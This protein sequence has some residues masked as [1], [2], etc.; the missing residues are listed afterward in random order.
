MDKQKPEMQRVQILKSQLPDP[1]FPEDTNT[2]T[3][4]VKNVEIPAEETTYWC[5]L[6][7][8]PKLKEKHHIIQVKRQFKQISLIIS[9]RLSRNVR[10]VCCHECVNLCAEEWQHPTG[11]GVL[12]EGWPS[13]IF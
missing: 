3:M 6:Q 1:D 8:L 5:S 4:K 13:S 9:T 2:F 12:S 10:N 11:F 7:K